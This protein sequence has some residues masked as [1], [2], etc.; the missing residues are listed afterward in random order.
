VP[1][2]RV[3]H[4]RDGLMVDKVGYFR[5]SEDPETLNLTVPSGLKRG[6]QDLGSWVVKRFQREGDDRFLTFRVT[7]FG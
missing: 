5:G 2:G 3:R 1:H 7:V 4:L 6:P